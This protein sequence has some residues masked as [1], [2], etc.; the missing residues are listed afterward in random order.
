MR[1]KVTAD[2][3][4]SYEVSVQV[5]FIEDCRE[6]FVDPA[7]ITITQRQ[8]KLTLTIDDLDFASD[9]QN[10]PVEGLKLIEEQPSESVDAGI[11]EQQ[12]DDD[13]ELIKVENHSITIDPPKMN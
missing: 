7:V 6:Q 4:S 1:L 11:S 2:G 3:G 5:T 13:L 8:R 12:F 10:C 9:I